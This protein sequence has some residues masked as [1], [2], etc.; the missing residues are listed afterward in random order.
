MNKYRPMPAINQSSTPPYC[1]NAVLARHV[2]A[3]QRLQS[4]AADTG[5][6]SG[7]LEPFRGILVG[8]SPLQPTYLASQTS[9]SCRVWRIDSRALHTGNDVWVACASFLPS[10]TGAQDSSGMCCQAPDAARQQQR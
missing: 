1:S 3:K 6:A 9:I 2:T 7:S 5:S 8:D 10:V 4:L